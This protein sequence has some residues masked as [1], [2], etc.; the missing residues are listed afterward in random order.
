MDSVVVH[1]VV[2]SMD[3]TVRCSGKLHVN[4][5]LIENRGM[6]YKMKF[7]V[8]KFI[9][10]HSICKHRCVQIQNRHFSNPKRK[11]IVHPIGNAI[12][13]RAV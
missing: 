5:F 10:L 2:D 1:C 7:N 12:P 11:V 3:G 6:S 4:Y 13:R 9:Y 8:H